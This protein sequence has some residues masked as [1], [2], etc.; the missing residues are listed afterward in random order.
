MCL[1]LLILQ[2]S[3]LT[4]DGTF[5]LVPVTDLFKCSITGFECPDLRGQVSDDA[6]LSARGYVERAIKAVCWSIIL[7]NPLTMIT[8]DRTEHLTI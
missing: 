3:Q 2:V 5:S 8:F 7:K 1:A 6:V 4:V